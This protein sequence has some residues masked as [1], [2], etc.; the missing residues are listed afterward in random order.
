[1]LPHSRQYLNVNSC[2]IQP[3]GT[4]IKA[5]IQDSYKHTILTVLWD[6]KRISCILGYMPMYKYKHKK[7]TPNNVDKSILFPI[8]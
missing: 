2:K 8:F 4:V 5:F 6:E 1:M 7:N 3:N